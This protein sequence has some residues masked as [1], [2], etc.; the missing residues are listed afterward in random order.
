MTMTKVPCIL[1]V[2]LI[3][4]PSS[5]TIA[6]EDLPSF[7]L[8][9]FASYEKFTPAADLDAGFGFGIAAT[10]SLSASILLEIAAHTGSAREQFDLV[11]RTASLQV[12]HTT[13]Q[14]QVHYLVVH[15]PSI[16]DAYATA[17]LGLFRLSTDEQHVSLGA[18]GQLRVPGRS[19]TRA[20]S[21]VGM[22]LSRAFSP[23]VAVRLE[24]QL[25]LLSPLSDSQSNF[26][27]SGGVTFVVF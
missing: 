20:L 22:V 17:G 7:S 15:L 26:M 10:Y 12:R 25:M 2:F 5:M 9:P 11:G 3:V 8:T 27:I 24:P 23:G 6:Q 21:S 1:F 13:Y 16:A 14:L 19:E 18:V 4:A